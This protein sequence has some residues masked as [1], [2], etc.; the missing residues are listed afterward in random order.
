M[1][2]GADNLAFFNLGESA[3]PRSST[4]PVP[5]TKFFVSKMVEIQTFGWKHPSANAT[6]FAPFEI[7]NFIRKELMPGL[8]SF[9]IPS[10][11]RPRAFETFLGVLF[12]PFV[13]PINRAGPTMITKL[14][15]LF[16]RLMA[17][18]VFVG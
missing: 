6:G 2:I 12:S 18:A 7:R 4:A 16:P 5:H 8:T 13:S 11:P 9:G 10:M 17:I 15:G 14:T 3:F 1:T